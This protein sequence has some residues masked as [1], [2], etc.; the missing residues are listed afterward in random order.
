MYPA[1]PDTQN[2]GTQQLLS[3]DTGTDDLGATWKTSASAQKG[4]QV[5]HESL[6]HHLQESASGIPVGP[7]SPTQRK[8]T[9]TQVRVRATVT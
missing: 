5:H 7:R 9:G 1:C 4:S 3:K 8:K 6:I 2:A